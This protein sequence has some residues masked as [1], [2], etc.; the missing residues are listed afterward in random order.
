MNGRPR[1]AAA[2]FRLRR[3]SGGHDLPDNFDRMIKF[4]AK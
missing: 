4:A 1:A 2:D 3:R